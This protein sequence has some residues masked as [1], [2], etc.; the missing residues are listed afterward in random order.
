M[1]VALLELALIAPAAAGVALLAAAPFA[2]GWMGEQLWHA[3][4]SR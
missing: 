1:I 3:W 4:R 2:A